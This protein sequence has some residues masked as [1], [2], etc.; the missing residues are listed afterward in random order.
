MRYLR[1]NGEAPKHS[2][3]VESR[4]RDCDPKVGK[5]S[6]EAWKDNQQDQLER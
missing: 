2:G 4:S 3:V 6:F 5:R 1:V